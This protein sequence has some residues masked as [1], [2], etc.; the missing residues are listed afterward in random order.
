[1]GRVEDSRVPWGPS[2]WWVNRHLL[3]CAWSCSK[4]QV[5]LCLSLRQEHPLS[6]LLVTQATAC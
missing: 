5:E 3:L 1:M 4:L 6:L 2:C